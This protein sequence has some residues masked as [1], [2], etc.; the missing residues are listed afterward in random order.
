MP[1]WYQ[2]AWRRNVVDM[3]IA[4][5]DP[6]FLSQFDPAT[7]VE[8]LRLCGAQSA[9]VYVHS[10]AGH[11]YY[12]TEVG[13]MHGGI[14]PDALGEVIRLCHAHD[15]AVV[16]YYSL[17]YDDHAYRTHPEWRIITA[18]GREAAEESRYG[19]CC[20]NSAYRDYARAHAEEFCRLF[21][22][23]GVRFDMTFWPTVCYCQACRARFDREVGGEMP[24]V[25]DWSDPR[26]VALQRRR[27]AWLVEFAQ[28]MTRAVKAIKPHATV[29]HQSST[30]PLNWRFGVTTQLVEANDFLQGDFYGD[31]LQGSFVRKLFHNLSSSPPYGFETSA[32]ISLGNHTGLKPE[33]LLRA[34]ASACLADAGA[35]V[36][37]DAIDPVG[38]MNRAVYERMARAFRGMPAYEPFLGGELVQDVGVYLSIESKFDPAD[39]GKPADDPALSPHMPHLGAVLGACRALIEH[40]VPYGVITRRDLGR[41]S[42]HRVIVLPNVLMMDDEEAAALVSYVRQGGA[43]YV[44]GATSRVDTG[45]RVRPD[46]ALSEV[47]GVTYSGETVETFTYMAPAP[48]HEALFPG[49]TRDHPLGLPTSQTRVIARPG[50]QVLGH[51]VLPYTARTEAR[52]YVSIHSDPPG[53]ATDD[54][55]VVL[56]DFGEGRALYLTADLER[57]ELHADAFAGL[58]RF[59]AGPFTVEAD[60]PASVE[61]TTFHQ[62]KEKRLRVSLVNFQKELPNVPIEAIRVRLRLTGRIPGALWLLPD[63]RPWP[64]GLSEDAVEFVVPRLETLA[65]FL[66]EY[67]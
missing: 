41:L 38:T 65:M 9:V 29:E 23:E 53:V 43:L 58:I 22:L 42:Q 51:A 35:F 21:D 34:K 4:D 15:I 12:P 33:A 16:L 14:R 57:H 61:V 3:H 11:C 49:Y 26:W 1:P 36:F 66:L 52:R 40:H 19:V 28:S 46:F 50:A 44:S 39:N 55:A 64:Y 62:P 24:R 48:G 47:L 60:A 37:I 59:L 31:A 6:R 20:P 56:H 7:Y 5:W 18:S 67:A 63:R 30:Y 25:V 13:H 10:H 54:P 27:E 32:T 8:M 2:R 17:I 45:G